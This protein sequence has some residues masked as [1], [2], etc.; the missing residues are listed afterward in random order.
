MTRARASSVS[1]SDA[2]PSNIRGYDPHRDAGDRY[3]YDPKL[4]DLRVDF[5]RECV[6]HV[7]GELAGQPFDLQP[8][9]ED[10]VRT[11]FGW[12]DKDTGL[13]RY[14]EAWCEIPRGN[15]KSALCSGLAL[16]LLYVDNEP[17]AEVVSAAADRDQAGIVF[18][19]AKEM[20]LG[21]EVLNAH[22]KVLRTS[23]EFTET[24]S[25]YRK[26]SADAHTKHGL[27]LHGLVADEV[28]TWRDRELWDTL[29]T[30]MGKRRQPISI[31]ITTAGH[32]RDSIAWELHDYALRV[33]DGSVNDPAF[34]PVIYAAE[35]SMDWTDPATWAHANPNLGVSIPLEYIERECRK[36]QDVP[37]YLNTFLR[38]HLNVWTQNR[39]RWLP[40]EKWE[41]NT[42]P[43]D[44]ADLKGR[45]C[46]AGLDLSA[47]TD[48]SALV[49]VFPEDGD[50]YTVL[51][52]FWIP[53]DPDIRE[54][55]RRD[56][57]AYDVFSREGYVDLCPGAVIDQQQIRK[58]INELAELYNI[59]EIAIDRWNAS[60][61]AIRLRDDGHEVAF[62]GQGFRSMSGPSKKLEELVI[63]GRIAH[64]S[65]PL[66]RAN[67]ERVEIMTDPAGNI[68]PTKGK[69]AERIDGVVALLMG[70]GRA[71]VREDDANVYEN[72]GIRSI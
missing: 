8:W 56:R 30:S 59:R 25:F 5:F 39:T 20:V 23:I 1:R 12:I 57:V 2:A 38:L 62:F 21:D 18:D 27:N 7:K 34:L 24:R 36:A 40:I 51:P 16:A 19:S 42:T 11:I 49:L 14:R 44:A 53:S 17:G 26:V 13:R 47:T 64:G 15:G 43:V 35:P 52:H 28:H 4:A 71:M 72:R 54:R 6:R 9:Q 45:E 61:L 29:H 58:K 68:K 10:I 48:L 46:Y 63:D 55:S 70:L 3:V 33:R 41:A 65:H 67:I 31:A 50:R 37:G 22:S 66:L 69:S 32:S 60:D